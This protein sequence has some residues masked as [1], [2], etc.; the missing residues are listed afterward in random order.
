MWVRGATFRISA[1]ASGRAGAMAFRTQARSGPGKPWVKLR[2]GG[3]AARGFATACGSCS[4]SWMY[5]MTAA[6]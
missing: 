2:T 1:C 4:V 5:A 6:K 3:V